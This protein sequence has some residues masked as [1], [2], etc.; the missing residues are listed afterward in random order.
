[1]S[2]Q[3]SA[4]DF[5]TM[6]CSEQVKVMGGTSEA[7]QDAHRLFPGDPQGPGSSSSNAAEQEVEAGSLRPLYTCA[8]PWPRFPTPLPPAR[9]NLCR[10][11]H[12]WTPPHTPIT[13]PL[14]M[15]LLQGIPVFFPSPPPFSAITVQKALL[16]FTQGT[17]SQLGRTASW[18]T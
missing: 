2:G 1:M 10:S 9:L 4:S 15:S 12:P 14:L 5:R 13:M 16:T 6:L 18:S 17:G 11:H 8:E 7:A 3:G